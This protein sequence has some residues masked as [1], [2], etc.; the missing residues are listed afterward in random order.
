MEESPNKPGQAQPF[1]LSSTRTVPKMITSYY[2]PNRSNLQRIV[3]GVSA[4]ENRC[5]LITTL[6]K[7]VFFMRINKKQTKSNNVALTAVE[8][9]GRRCA[10]SEFFSVLGK[11]VEKSM[12]LPME[13]LE[14]IEE[15]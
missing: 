1:F 9:Y 12:D 5:K 14:P 6:L 15:V 7:A 10:A 2:Y 3:A 8:S 13:D 4:G 11:P